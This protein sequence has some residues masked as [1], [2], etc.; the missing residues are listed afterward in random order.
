MACSAG[1]LSTTPRRGGVI[2]RAGATLLLVASVAACGEPGSIAPSGSAAPSSV[3]SSP[4][5]SS[6]ALT[7]SPTPANMS[8]TPGPSLKN[9]E[10]VSGGIV[11]RDTSTD[12]QMFHGLIVVPG[13]FV[14]ICDPTD[15]TLGTACTSSDGIVWAT[16]PS[17]AIFS[18]TGSTPFRAKFLAQSPS[19]WLAA[20]G[21]FA[22]YPVT[23]YAVLWKSTDG[24]HWSQVPASQA[25]KGFQVTALT[26][27]N[28]VFLAFGRGGVL[29]SSDG[30]TWHTAPSGVIPVV[31]DPNGKIAFGEQYDGTSLASIATCV[32]IDGKTWAAINR[33]DPADDL[34]SVVSPT[35]GG[36]LATAYDGKRQVNV[37]L[38][39]DDGIN[40]SVSTVSP[41]MFMITRVGDLLLGIGSADSS[42]N[43][44]VLWSST[45]GGQTWSHVTDV[46]GNNL[47]PGNWYVAGDRIL[48]STG[49]AQFGITA[50]GHLP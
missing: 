43:D 42:L 6:A 38:R 44:E 24:I 40:W 17:P 9:G 41:A 3:P 7:S 39:S 18:K 12:P 16:K 29:A 45:D 2:A 33:P 32:S 4:S 1:M 34:V 35:G 13:G 28:G 19:L 26:Y 23:P 48:L 8:P 21:V 10:W 11:W 37:A 27:W 50:A 47:N 31:S 25:L 30:V 15:T 20:E 36:Y 14:A 22:E 46:N 49:G 5:T